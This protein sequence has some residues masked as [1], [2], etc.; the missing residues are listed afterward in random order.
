MYK[1]AKNVSESIKLLNWFASEEAEA[2]YPSAL[3]PS[4]IS[5]WQ[6]Q[7][8]LLSPIETA[9][10]SK[11]I[12]TGRM[13]LNSSI[14][15]LDRLIDRCH[16]QNYSPDLTGIIRNLNFIEI[17]VKRLIRI[18][19]SDFCANEQ[20][21]Q[22][23]ANELLELCSKNDTTTIQ[24]INYNLKRQNVLN[25][26]ILGPRNVLEALKAAAK[27]EKYEQVLKLF[28]ELEIVLKKWSR[29]FPLENIFED[30]TALK[31]RL[32]ALI[33]LNY[34]EDALQLI[35]QSP[36]E[37]LLDDLLFEPVLSVLEAARESTRI[38]DLIETKLMQI[39][40]E[41]PGLILRLVDNLITA[42]K[43]PE[44]FEYLKAI[45]E[46]Y[47]N[48][49]EITEAH[50]FF[51]LGLCAWYTGDQSKLTLSHFLTAA[52]LNPLESKH[53]EWIGKFYW[54]IEGDAQKSLKCLIKS[55]N[56]DNFNLQAAILFSEVK[57][58]SF[59]DCELDSQWTNS[60]NDCELVAK[61]LDP[62]TKQSSQSRNRRLFYYNAVAQFHLKNYLEASVSF[63]AALK[64]NSSSTSLLSRDPQ[65]SDENCL[66]WLGEAYLRSGRLGSAM[67]TFSRLANISKDNSAAFLTAQIGLAAVYLKSNN[68]IEAVDHLTEIPE[69]PENDNNYFHK[70]GLERAKSFLALARFYL[71]Q[72]RFISAMRS[73]CNLLRT[74]EV[75]FNTADRL[76]NAIF[77]TA[78]GLRMAS[79]ALC[80]AHKYQNISK[81]PAD[82][83][84][85]IDLS[86]LEIN[87]GLQEISSK[88][89]STS[90]AGKSV[91]LALAAISA[92]FKNPKKYSLSPFWLQIAISLS[93]LSEDRFDDFI[94][95]AAGNPIK[96]TDS[97]AQDKAQGHHIQA[98]I[99]A[100]NLNSQ[101][102]AQHHFICALK[103]FESPGLWI[104]LGRFYLKAGDWQLASESFQR[105][106]ALD[107]E[108]LIAAFELAQ[109]SGTV[110]GR[111][112]AVQVAQRAFSTQPVFFT[113]EF[114]QTLCKTDG[115]LAEY[116]A[117]YLQR[118]LNSNNEHCE[119]SDGIVNENFLTKMDFLNYLN[120]Q[121]DPKIWLTPQAAPF[122]CE[123]LLKRPENEVAQSG[124]RAVVE[125]LL[126]IPKERTK[127]ELE[128]LQQ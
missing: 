67:K 99:Y 125:G 28:S 78:E 65:I 18:V 70:V 39:D 127:N 80:L 14:D 73:L 45:T 59:N 55:L 38:I 98:L 43:Y 5:L 10:I 113:E 31:L 76:R 119:N 27:D 40:P 44:A 97:T 3:L 116:A 101:P 93:T 69:I 54:R 117:I 12:E 49:D 64:G 92:A 2:F 29:A 75:I 47:K 84:A 42:Q 17:L 74:T 25:D 52:K 22:E 57:L 89:P 85:Q 34:F 118:L 71:R 115:P 50:L 110:E 6:E 88:I 30:A 19:L 21:R 15:S 32:K 96:E 51:S 7:F 123:F 100:K 128:E 109:A 20:T 105:A 9:Q 41:H 68:P 46:A 36:Q 120:S 60:F 126:S 94:I 33:S 108:D 122:D 107:P 72:G 35:L 58:K 77:N 56:L 8:D 63:Q 87:S 121:E 104:D 62:F 112:A 13:R 124:W 79:D 26:E 106:L 83:F 81:F 37:D 90:L 91:L 111:E 4:K 1:E 86:D 16:V 114:A 23:Y 66:Q 53:F 95:S 48:L 102:S 61:L 24:C 11:D 82:E 103:H